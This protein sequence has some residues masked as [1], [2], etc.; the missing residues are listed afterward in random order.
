[1]LEVKHDILSPFNGS[2]LCYKVITV[3]QNISE[4]LFPK[5]LDICGHFYASCRLSRYDTARK[6][7]TVVQSSMKDEDFI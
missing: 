4:Q 6:T 7:A 3:S 2:L 1:M 5:S